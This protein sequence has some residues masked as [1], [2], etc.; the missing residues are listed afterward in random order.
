MSIAKNQ[1]VFVFLEVSFI[2]PRTYTINLQR[3]DFK[4][5]LLRQLKTK[6]LYIISGSAWS[7]RLQVKFD[8]YVA[9]SQGNYIQ[10]AP[11]K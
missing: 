2:W 5:F 6:D 1:S 8:H 4:H 9:S 10:S 3:C 11:N 7:N